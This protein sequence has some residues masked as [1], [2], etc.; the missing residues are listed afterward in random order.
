MELTTSRSVGLSL[1]RRIAARVDPPAIAAWT[2]AFAV[3][4]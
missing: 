4:A 3:V 2:L 1:P